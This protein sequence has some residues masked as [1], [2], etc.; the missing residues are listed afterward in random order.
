MCISSLWLAKKPVSNTLTPTKTS[1]TTDSSSAVNTI[2]LHQQQQQL[3]AKKRS[4]QSL[5]T[6]ADSIISYKKR[7]ISHRINR[8]KQI[9]ENHADHVAEIYFLQTGGNMMDYPTW[10]KKPNT[11]EFV[12]FMKKY[13]LEPQS[14]D[15][16]STVGGVTT[17]TTLSTVTASPTVQTVGQ[18][19]HSQNAT[20]NQP[21]PLISTNSPHGKRPFL[22]HTFFS[23]LFLL[24]FWANFFHSSTALCINP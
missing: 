6:D 1:V 13:L 20:Q 17:T 19:S 2:N 12:N 14:A 22:A 21:P 16:P 3:I 9:K 7:T 23:K 10:R 11:P 8:L 18:Q 5:G 24:L 15:T 4:A